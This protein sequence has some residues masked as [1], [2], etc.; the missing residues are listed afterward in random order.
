MM[1]VIENTLIEWNKSTTSREKLQHAYLS[2]AIV[3]LF[4]AGIVGL[5]N[6]E[7]GQKLLFIAI[8]AV[9]MFVVNAV[10]WALLQSFVLLRIK[11]RDTAIVKSKK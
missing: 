8:L 1:T 5:I 4:A 2:A 6:Y 10:A 11:D 3:L 9:S 7:L